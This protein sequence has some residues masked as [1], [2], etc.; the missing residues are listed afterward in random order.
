MALLGKHNS[1]AALWQC[2]AHSESLSCAGFVWSIAVIRAHGIV[3]FGHF[4]T[5]D[6]SRSLAHCNGASGP[7]P[8]P[9]PPRL[10]NRGCHP[11]SFMKSVVPGLFH[12]PPP[13]ALVLNVP[14]P[15]RDAVEGKGPQ[16]RPQRRLDRR[17]EEVFKAVGGGYCRLQMPLK[18]A[19]GVRETVAGH[20]LGAL[21]GGRG[22]NLRP[23]QCIPAP[24]P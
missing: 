23:F 6:G 9:P 19:L 22:V 21:E 2:V 13:L 11:G 17:L 5:G 20:R 10:L 4:M 14:L 12:G 15:P 16:R 24:K 3:R 1:V 18:P 7:F 8:P